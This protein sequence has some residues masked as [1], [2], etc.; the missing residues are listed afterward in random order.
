MED[1]TLF[2]MARY[3]DLRDYHDEFAEVAKSYL[4]DMGE[5]LAKINYQAGTLEHHVRDLN[6]QLT[7]FQV[8]NGPF[9]L[10][11]QTTMRLV[12]FSLDALVGGPDDDDEPACSV[13]DDDLNDT[14]QR[15]SDLPPRS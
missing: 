4:T 9:P 13:H 2:H 11:L 15:V 8:K 14:L 6:A 12:M 5:K 3:W 7:A 10:E 1:S